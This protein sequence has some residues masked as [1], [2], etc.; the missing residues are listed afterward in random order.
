MSKTLKAFKKDGLTITVNDVSF[1]KSG[2]FSIKAGY[3]Y[4]FDQKGEFIIFYDFK[5]VLN[6][7]VFKK[8]D[9]D[10][11]GE[12]ITFREWELLKRVIEYVL[13]NK[14]EKKWVR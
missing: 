12:E 1:F 5:N 6:S 11:K 4:N 13:D 3:V 8:G 14:E 9:F 2:G 10:K 7:S